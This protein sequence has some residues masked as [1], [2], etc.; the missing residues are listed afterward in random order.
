MTNHATVNMFHQRTGP[1][2]DVLHSYFTL[3]GDS[4]G[5]TLCLDSGMARWHVSLSADD[6]RCLAD[7]LS[8]DDDLAAEDIGIGR[9]IIEVNR[10]DDRVTLYVG[11]DGISATVSMTHDN[12]LE[13][14]A[15]LAA[16]ALTTK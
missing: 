5:I 9:A 6:A 10:S 16:L 4:S 14:A 7:A 3:H 8:T 11:N 1:V 13:L 15:N 2:P 12:A